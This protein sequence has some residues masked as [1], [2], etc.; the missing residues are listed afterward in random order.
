MTLPH[1]AAP[2]LA[3]AVLAG[4]TT[5]PLLCTANVAQSIVVEVRDAATGA[6]RAA[7]ASGT[8]RDG[9]FTYALQ[10]WGYDGSTPGN[11]LSLAG[12]YE[13]AGTY[14]VVLQ[15]PGYRDWSASGVR[16]TKGDCHVR[17][18][19]LRASLV[20]VPASSAAAR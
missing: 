6:P 12:P 19:T 17:T 3:L 7:G 11:L 15:R 13:R 4:C 5:G 10:P 2:S 16:V 20:A 14:A 18:I 8:V 9:G 1:R